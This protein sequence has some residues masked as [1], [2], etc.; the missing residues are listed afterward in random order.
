M[1]A[2]GVDESLGSPFARMRALHR[3]LQQTAAASPRPW[4][5]E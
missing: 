3:R 1:A 5:R 4:L 2:D